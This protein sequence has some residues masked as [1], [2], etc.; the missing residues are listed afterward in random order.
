MDNLKFAV[1]GTG[2]WSNFQIPAWFEVGGV[3]LVALYNRTASK[4]E[5][6]AHQYNIPRVYGDSE[7]L[8]KN[9]KLD[10]VDII[11]GNEVHAQHVFLAAKY[12]V[13]IICQKPMAT[14]WQTCQ[15]M[16]KV[17]KEAGVPFMIHENLRWQAPMR[18]V[19][20]VID[21]GRIG[22]PFRGHINLIGY[23]PLEYIEQPF[24]KELDK[25]SL[26]DLGS[27]VLDTARF[28]FGEPSS[29]Y[30]Q[31][32]RSRDDIRGE[33]VATVIMRMGDVICTVQTSN[34][35]R[36]SWNHYPD[37]LVFVEG[38][39]GSLE[40]TPDY[41]IKLNTDDGTISFR[42]DPPMYSWIRADQPHWHASI[43]AC[44]QNLLNQIKTGKQAETS[45]EDNLKTM[46]LIFKAYESAARNQVINL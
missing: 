18:K 44:N 12:K 4:A 14:D 22:K 40:L 38:N 23:S 27:H 26:M 42:V 32:L 30:C 31:H 36:T 41:W 5:K 28:F 20:Q 7:D 9:E 29:L 34:A 37:V 13:P 10:F 17:C 6:F 43:A 24:L 39:E 45:G 1:M 11:T 33:D 25:L 19:K 2:W 21:Q 35:T 3:E 8:F 16:V 46:N 15:K